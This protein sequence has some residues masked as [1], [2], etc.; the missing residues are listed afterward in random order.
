AADAAVRQLD[1]V[2]LAAILD[3][4]AAEDLAVDSDIAELVDDDRKAASVRLFEQVADQRCLAGAEKAGHDGTGHAI[5]GFHRVRSSRLASDGIRAIRPRLSAAGRSRNGM[6]PSW[7]DANS[8]APATRSC[9]LSVS[10]SPNRH[11]QQPPRSTAA[12]MPRRQ[13]PGHEA[14]RPSMPLPTAAA[15][16]SRTGLGPGR[17]ASA[18]PS[19]NRQVLHTMIVTPVGTTPAVAPE[20]PAAGSPD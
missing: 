17:A 1:D 12:P 11:L 2:L 7:D 20:S 19:R 8:R 15:R 5:D 3:A 16:V 6:N 10:S 18:G 4:A 13:R 9:A 14:C